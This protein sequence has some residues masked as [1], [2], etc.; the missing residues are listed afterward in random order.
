M[1]ANPAT[2]NNFFDH[3]K[4]VLEDNGIESP[5]NI[6][7]CDESGVQNVPKEQDVI[8]VVGREGQFTGSN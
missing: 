7:N 6:W 8:G 3:Y 2:V 4:E 5:L 1:C